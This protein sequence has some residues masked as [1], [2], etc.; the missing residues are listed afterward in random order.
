[1]TP[2][3][4]AWVAFAAFSFQMGVAQDFKRSYSI[5]QNGIIVIDTSGNIRVQGHKGQKIEVLAYKK[6]SD[7]D[8]IEIQDSSF[9]NRIV[10]SLR[11]P[12]FDPGKF[13]P[14][15]YPPNK[16]PPGKMP[17]RIFDID[18]SVDFEI[19]MPKSINCE[20]WLH[21]IKGTVDITNVSGRLLLRSE[22]GNVNVKDV[23]GFIR[24]EAFNGSVRVELGSQKEPSDMKFS[25]NS[26]DVTVIA[27]GNLDAVI[28]MSSDSGR[29]K[30]D[31]PLEEKD[32]R[33]GHKRIAEGKLGSGKQ[34]IT[35][36]SRFGGVN[37][38][39]K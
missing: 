23:H 36:E 22:R 39:K 10:L 34:K 2:K 9:G 15:K 1:M 26:G 21:S 30:T 25:S 33:Y 18:S 7:T 38:I 13:D 17:P 11:F 3:S 6:G 16:F 28:F 29:I 12:Q 31:F 20:T 5:P 8:S 35:I 32:D 27:P 24:G 19:M 14:G 37:L 4:L